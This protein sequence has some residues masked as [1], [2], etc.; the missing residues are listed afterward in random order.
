M[1]VTLADPYRG[2]AINYSNAG[3]TDD[4]DLL[5]F[6]TRPKLTGLPFPPDTTHPPY[7]SPHSQVTAASLLPHPAPQAHSHHE[8][9]SAYLSGQQMIPR[10]LPSYVYDLA[11]EESRKRRRS[12]EHEV[13]HDR[14]MD[15][16][17]DRHIRLRESLPTLSM[18]GQVSGS[19]PTDMLFSVH[20]DSLTSLP[21]TNHGYGTTIS[22]P[23]PQQ[24]HHR[25]PSHYTDHRGLESLSPT[26]PG[27]PPT[28]VGQ[29]GMPEPAPRPRGPKLKF[30]PEE[31]A[32]LVEL[33]EDKNLTWK[34]IADFFPGRTS[35]TLQ[36]RYC[37]KLKAKDV[38]WTDEMTQRLV[39][40]VNDYE[41]DRW[42][43]VAAKVGNGF[44]PAACREQATQYDLVAQAQGAAQRAHGAQEEDSLESVHEGLDSAHDSMGPVHDSMV[45]IH[46]GMGSMH[47]R[48]HDSMGSI[49]GAEGLGPAHNGDTLGV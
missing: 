14:A 7:E 23:L 2:F 6:D 26:Y 43:I 25:L 4:Q 27:G 42:R 49:H 46:D 1:S 15:R 12:I 5:S 37:T 47:D 21:P 35:G 41:N 17:I 45:P 30:T 16:S 19:E 18:D 32:L 8:S 33:K 40:A 3:K 13:D 24:H 28:V 38:I 11:S 48:M 39:R 9:S 10:H 34:Q 36:V 22:L 20:H 44:T 29:P 31:D